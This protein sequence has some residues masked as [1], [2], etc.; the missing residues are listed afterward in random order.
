MSAGFCIPSC[1]QRGRWASCG[2]Q[3][4]RAFSS[5]LPACRSLSNLRGPAGQYRVHFGRRA[6]RLLCGLQSFSYASSWYPPPPRF[7]PTPCVTQALLGPCVCLQVRNS[8]QRSRGC[9]LHLW[10]GPTWGAMSCA[11][12][13]SRGEVLIFDYQTRGVAAVWEGGHGCGL[14]AALRL[15]PLNAL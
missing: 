1:A 9:Q 15:A 10:G 3:E 11:A 2:L 7:S 14:P 8:L 13:C 4:C 12:G 6:L 5:C